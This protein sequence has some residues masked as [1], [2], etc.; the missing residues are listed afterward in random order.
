MISLKYI[1]HYAIG[2]IKSTQ[3]KG[4][5]LHLFRLGD[6]MLR[7]IRSKSRPL[8]HVMRCW[9]VVAPHFVEVKKMFRY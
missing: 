7:I 4:S 9:S 2:E 8:L 3:D 1:S 6:V 5:A